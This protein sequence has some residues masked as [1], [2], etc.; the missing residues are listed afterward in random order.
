MLQ[1]QQLCAPAVASE[2]WRTERP[3]I[4]DQLERQLLPKKRIEII[5]Y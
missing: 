3:V 2:Q 4:P 5:T 1:G